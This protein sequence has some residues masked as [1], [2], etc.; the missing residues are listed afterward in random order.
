MTP[1]ADVPHLERVTAACGFRIARIRY[2]TPIIGGFV[3]NVA[4]RMAERWMTRRAA[5][6]RGASAGQTGDQDVRAARARAKARIA[7]GGVTYRA[8]RLLTWVMMVDVALLGRVRSGPF[9]ALLV[10]DG[11]PAALPGGPPA[12]APR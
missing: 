1:L 10:K 7:G 6:G 5:E 2:Y 8:L 4:M 9:F 12:P 3:E 11:P